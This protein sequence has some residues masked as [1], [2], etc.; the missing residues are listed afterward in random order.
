MSVLMVCACTLYVCPDGLSNDHEKLNPVP[1]N[2]ARMVLRLKHT[3]R[4]SKYLVTKLV[5]ISRYC[6]FIS[7]ACPPNIYVQFIGT[8]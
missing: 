7:D 2:E 3:F 1:G 4:S 6:N 5:P 8:L